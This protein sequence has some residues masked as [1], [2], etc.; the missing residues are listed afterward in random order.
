MLLFIINFN[1]Q[2]EFDIIFKDFFSY[3]NYII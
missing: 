3:K 2:C 1:N